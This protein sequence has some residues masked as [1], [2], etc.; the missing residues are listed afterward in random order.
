MVDVEFVIAVQ[1]MLVRQQGLAAKI[2]DAGRLESV[3]GRVEN[4]I[5]YGLIDH[6]LEAAAWYAAA[7][8][9][10]H[11]FPDAN[12]RTAFVV[13]LTVIEKSGYAVQPEKA[14][15]LEDM[16]VEL[17][18]DNTDPESLYKWLRKNTTP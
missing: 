18:A 4:R 9:R 3:L 2:P 6:P 14:D 1:E 12:K 15:E 10:G 5:A 8:S 11:C 16:V 17:A 7:I 13:M